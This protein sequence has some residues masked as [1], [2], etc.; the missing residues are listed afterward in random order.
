MRSRT[1][2]TKLVRDRIPEIIAEA[3]KECEVRVM[4]EGEFRAALMEK[5]VEEAQEAAQA[6]EEKI[7]IELADLLEVI[8]AVCKVAGLDIRDVQKI[9]ENR[10]IERGGFEKRYQLVWSED[11]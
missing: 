6:V 3:G 5:L 2:Y 7:I 11:G 1:T 4:E 9:Q 8:D 10:R